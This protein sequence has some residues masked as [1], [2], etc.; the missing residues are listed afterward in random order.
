MKIVSVGDRVKSG[1][2][3]L[4]S[5][6]HHA[7][8]YFNSSAFVVLADRSVGSGPISIVVE[9]EILEVDDITVEADAWLLGGRRYAFGPRYDSSLPP[10]PVNTVMIPF[11]AD[12]LR[13]R[14]PPKS[15]V[16]LLDEARAANF[17]PGFEQNVVKQIRDGAR[18]L[19][20]GDWAQGAQL[21][22][23][24]GFGLTPSGDDFLAGF[25]IAGH[26]TAPSVSEG[27]ILLAH[28][29]SYIMAAANENSLT[30]AFLALAAEGRVNEAMKCLL[31]ALGG[32]D[33][34][35]ARSAAD[36]V[37][38]HGETSGADILTGLVLGMQKGMNIQLPTS[39]RRRP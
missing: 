13:A 35:A 7:A 19:L 24:C 30:H 26:L 15:L 14:A 32:T 23:G 9:G 2:Y 18:R 37:L 33:A 4:H 10:E 17:R 6:F 38:A 20:E 5:R 16:F 27:N 25:L 1:T 34:E 22:R 31:V 36:R 8:N 11:L 28:A 21:L 29:H 3:R 12:H 39:N